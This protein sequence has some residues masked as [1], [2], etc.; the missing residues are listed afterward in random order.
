MAKKQVHKV[1]IKSINGSLLKENIITQIYYDGYFFCYID[2]DIEPLVRG[3]H[4]QY[5]KE[6]N[7]SC[8]V[9]TGNSPSEIQTRLY[10]YY[11]E[12]FGN[13]IKEEKII[14]YEIKFNSKKHY[15]NHN[16]KIDRAG[17]TAISFD[18]HIHYLITFPDG[19]QKIFSDPYKG[20]AN[21]C[22]HKF[23]RTLDSFDKDWMM[24]TEE[25][26]KFFSETEI[27]MEKMVEK[28]NMFFTQPT[29]ELT[30][31]IDNKIKLLN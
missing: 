14:A 12:F 8:Y 24:W 3:E 13:N 4:K 16:K 17:R 31:S 20:Y 7:T 19:R 25:R 21:I 10:Q 1:H 27:T 18:W 23:D 22:T 11:S 28:I 5:R 6:K 2:S 15:F 26:E 30:E 29:L 9:L